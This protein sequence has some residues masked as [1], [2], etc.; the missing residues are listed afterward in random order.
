M[1][2]ITSFPNSRG[3]D[4]CDK[5]ETMTKREISY[6]ANQ[7]FVSKKAK[8]NYRTKSSHSKTTCNNI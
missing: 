3:D 4:V 8:K 6:A 5:T 2:L 1:G 7:M